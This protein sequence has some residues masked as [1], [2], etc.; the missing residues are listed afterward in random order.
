MSYLPKNKNISQD[1]RFVWGDEFDGE[2]LDSNK[3]TLRLKMGGSKRII[4]SSDSDTIYVKDGKLNLVAHKMPDGTYKVPTSVITQDKMNFKYGYVEIK[5]KV[6]FQKGVWPSFWMQSTANEH[7]QPLL[8]SKSEM[9]AE[10]DVFEVFANNRIAACIHKWF[11]K[12]AEQNVK[13]IRNWTFANAYKAPAKTLSDEEFSGINNEY[14]IYGYEWTEDSV[15]MYF[16]GELYAEIDIKNSYSTGNMDDQY[17]S[18]EPIEIFNDKSGRDMS[19]F[20]DPQYLIFNNHL[21][22]EGV[23]LAS[24]SITE[25]EDFISATYSIEY[26]RVFQKEGIGDFAIK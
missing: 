11:P 4:V 8:S 16:D 6:P 14:H 25:V 18:T 1:Y 12:P 20:Q 10:V 13:K 26:C 3:W 5:A 9:M 7:M 17:F 22:D 23:S 15:K 21:F 19:C 2:T 24:A